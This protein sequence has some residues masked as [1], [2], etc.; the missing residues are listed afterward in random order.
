M[1]NYKLLK[2]NFFLVYIEKISL[3]VATATVI[4]IRQSQTSQLGAKIK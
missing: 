3:E 4:F 2:C 1:I